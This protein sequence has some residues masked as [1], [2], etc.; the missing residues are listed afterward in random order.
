MTA[1]R[2]PAGFRHRYAAWSLDFAIL[3]AAAIA[4]T[5]PWLQPAARAVSAAFSG[6]W[7]DIGNALAEA[8]MAGIPLPALVRGLLHDPVLLDAARALQAALWRLLWPPL[9]A[10]MV[11]SA[12]WHVLGTASP[13]GASPGKRMLGLRVGDRDDGRLRLPAAAGRHVAALLSWLTLNVGHLMA[14]PAPH[15]A[16]HDRIARTR[17]SRAAYARRLPFAAAAWIGLQVVALAL[18]LAWLL[19]RYVAAIAALG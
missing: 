19:R 7:T 2:A 15:R 4:I 17:V 13:L 16:L 11:L 8:L 3:A 14:I 9:L 18:L 1:G 5:W 6:L 12:C 10:Y